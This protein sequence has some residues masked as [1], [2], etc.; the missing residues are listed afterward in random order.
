ML[1]WLSHIPRGAFSR[2]FNN[3][4]ATAI[5]PYDWVTVIVHFSVEGP[6][7]RGHFC[8]A[9]RSQ[10]YVD[11][12]NEFKNWQTPLFKVSQIQ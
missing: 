6:R 7:K 5:E 12:P 8:L 11:R 10:L 1:R 3:K 2:V 4:L 9:N